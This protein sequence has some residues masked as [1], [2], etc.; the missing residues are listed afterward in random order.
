M[1]EGKLGDVA[2]D[3]LRRLSPSQDGLPD[4]GPI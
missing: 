4:R 3:A 2:E 1:T